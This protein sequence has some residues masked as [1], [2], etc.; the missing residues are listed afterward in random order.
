MLKEIVGTYLELPTTS[1]T[2]EPI[3]NDEVLEPGTLLEFLIT[4]RL[5]EELLCEVPP[6]AVRLPLR[7]CVALN[8]LILDLLIVGVLFVG[9]DFLVC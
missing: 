4:L 9:V 8:I 3:M 1:P 7:F 5:F 6:L 2:A